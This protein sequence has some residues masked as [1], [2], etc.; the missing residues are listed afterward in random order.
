MV[1]EADFAQPKDQT[2]G[3]GANG[4]ALGFVDKPPQGDT[5]PALIESPLDPNL[6]MSD[7]ATSNK[8]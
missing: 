4:S 8:A 7:T 5:Q 3:N 2:N 1:H 6:S